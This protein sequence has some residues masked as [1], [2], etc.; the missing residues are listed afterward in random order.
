MKMCNTRLSHLV[1]S[2][3]MVSCAS[4][5]AATGGIQEVAQANATVDAQTPATPAVQ[6]AWQTAVAAQEQTTTGCFLAKT[7]STEWK[8]VPCR[9]A[10]KAQP[11]RRPATVTAWMPTAASMQAEAIT[12]YALGANGLIRKAQ[13]SFPVV[14]GVHT[15]R[16][17]GTTASTDEFSL[18]LDSDAN[19]ST[20][21][22]AGHPDCHV[23]QQFIYAMHGE[24]TV[25]MQ[26]WLINYGQACPGGWSG[27]GSGSCYR[28]SAA[29]AVPPIATTRLGS[30]TFT[31]EV[32][33]GGSDTV[34]LLDG[35]HAYRVS[36][37]DSVLQLAT[38]WSGADFNILG[39]GNGGRAFFNTGSLVT[40]RLAV[41]DGTR[42]AP[43]C[44]GN[45]AVSGESNNLHLGNCTASAGTSPSIQ[46]TGR[47]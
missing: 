45:G 29:I 40:T 46:F 15:I 18:Q 42:K 21:A 26:Y 35:A 34:T 17:N 33:A 7:P 23:W 11:V 37:P 39:N 13:G 12:D 6:H 19:A 36:A 47:N 2:V 14:S 3:V 27:E 4:A 28:N 31:V 1:A 10:A 32:S 24:G 20:S 8:R 38:V 41:N 16:S 30:L 9:P 44:I 22:C 25:F 5:Y 43:R